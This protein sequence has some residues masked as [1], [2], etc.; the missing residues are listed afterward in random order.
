M[1]RGG[2]FQQEGIKFYTGEFKEKHVLEEGDLVVAMTDLTQKAEVLGKPAIIPP[3]PNVGKILASLD[4]SIIKPKAQSSVSVG[5]LYC[6]FM[7]PEFQGRMFSYANG[8]TVL[9]LSKKGLTEYRF[10]L[11]DDNTLSKFNVLFSKIWN[12]IT[13]NN[14]QSKSLTALRDA[15]LPRLMSGK[16][17]VKSEDYD[18]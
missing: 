14:T 1:K 9:H 16:L 4:L 3:I 2:G 10:I 7:R 5:F 11:P 17:R 12:E 13:N 15:L 18:T 6:S 8:T